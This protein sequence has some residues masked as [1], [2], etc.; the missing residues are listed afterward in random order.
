M[1]NL[2]FNVNY[3]VIFNVTSIHYTLT[4]SIDCSIIE[5]DHFQGMSAV[6]AGTLQVET[7]T[8]NLLGTQVDM[9]VVEYLKYIFSRVTMAM[10]VW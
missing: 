7:N 10:D 6:V 1:I 2:N 9:E 8:L 5:H 3:T 4:E